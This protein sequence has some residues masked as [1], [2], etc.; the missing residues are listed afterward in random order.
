MDLNLAK[1]ITLRC[2][3]TLPNRLWKAAMTE[4]FADKDRLPGSEACLATYRVWAKGGWGLVMTGNVDVDPAYLGSPGDIAVDSSIPREKTLAA[5]RAWAEACSENGTKA[6]VQINH[7]GRQA[8]FTKSIA[9]SAVPLNLGPGILPWMLRSLIY[10]TPREMTVN[11]IHDVVMKFA[12]AARLAADSGFA[13]VEIHA[14]HGYLLAQ[15]L[16][17]ASNKRTDAYGGSAKGR[18]RIVVDII[19]AIRSS[20]PETFCVGIKFN[21]TDHH[22][23]TE[24]RSCI[25]QLHLISDAGVDFLEISGGT[26]ENPTFNLGVSDQ[27]V[28]ATTRAR[29]AFFVDFAKSIRSQLIGLPLMVTGGF[30]T[31]QGMETALA[32]DNCDAVGIARPAVLTPY[33][34]RNIIL[35]QNVVDAEAIARAEKIDT[36][37]IAKWIGIKAIGVGAETL[38]YIKKIQSL[39]S[40]EN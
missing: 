26:F 7:P 24:M 9:P 29:E 10:G 5:W 3:L 38:W 2:G 16:S 25:E 30:R 12:K 27:R 15:F 8:S 36:P 13:G 18:A 31:R 4:D 11:E 37:T 20:V 17:A 33:L 40:V 19:H 6:I 34:P 14:A 32:E 35:N 1:P 23:E 28:K 39:G 22:S 21:S